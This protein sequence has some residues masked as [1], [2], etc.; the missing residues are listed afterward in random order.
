MMRNIVFKLFFNISQQKI[1][2]KL[3]MKEVV[4]TFRSHNLVVTDYSVLKMT[5]EKLTEQSKLLNLKMMKF[6]VRV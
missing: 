1:S 6:K 4:F 3:W 2:R 5:E